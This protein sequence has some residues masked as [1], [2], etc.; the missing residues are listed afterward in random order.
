MILLLESKD[1]VYKMDFDIPSMK[2]TFI[3]ILALL[4]RSYLFVDLLSDACYPII[5]RNLI[6]LEAI[7]VILAF[8]RLFSH[9]E[10]SKTK[11]GLVVERKV[12]S[13]TASP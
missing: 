1:F 7:K 13:L 11:I 9:P 10:T 2:L 8:P 12:Q 6:V 4:W 3:Y 5:A